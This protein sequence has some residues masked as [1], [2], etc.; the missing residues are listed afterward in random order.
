VAVGIDHNTGKLKEIAFDKLGNQYREHPISKVVF[1][2]FQLPKWD[3]V[4]Q[5]AIKVQKACSFYRLLGMDIALSKEGPILIE[6]NAN[7]DVVFQEQ[8]SGPLLRDKRV[9]QEFAQ[10]D[11]LINKFQK[12]LLK[13]K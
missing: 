10:Y 11:L 1:K 3:E 2:D 4:I 12:D 5:V 13:D 9:L 6:V 7:P 8:T